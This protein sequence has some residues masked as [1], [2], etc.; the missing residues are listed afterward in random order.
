MRYPIAIEPGTAQTAFGV[1]VPDLPG[2]FS[3]GDT[4]EDAIANAEAAVLMALEDLAERGEAFPQPSDLLALRARNKDLAN[5]LWMLLPVDESTITGPAERINITVPRRALA[6]I[7]EAAEAAN[8]SR[9]AFLVN[10]ALEKARTLGLGVREPRAGGYKARRT[11][12][13]R[14][15]SVPTRRRKR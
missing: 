5:W 15:G 6:R 1:V 3:A 14:P 13:V 12:K 2:C 10:A 4:L 7:D 9:S 8:E 11:A